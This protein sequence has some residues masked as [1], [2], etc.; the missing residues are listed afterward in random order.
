MSDTKKKIELILAK[1]NYDFYDLCQIVRILRSDKGC[2]WDREQTHKTIRNDFIEETYEVVE[3]ID[4]SDMILLREELGDVMLQVVFHSVIEEENGKFDINDVSNDIC[5]KLIH[6]H[7]HVFGDVTADTSA[8]VLDNW[9]KIKREEK[10]R[11]TVY[12]SM[13]SVPPMLPALMRARKLGARAAK[14]GFDFSSPDQAFEKIEEESIELKEA[15]R[16]DNALE[17]I[18][19]LLFSVVNVARILGI[20]P[21]EALNYSNNKFM[22]RFRLLEQEITMKGKSIQELSADELDYYYKIA[23]NKEKY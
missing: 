20:D 14:V 8:Q 16:T 15:M 5:K 13:K 21:E 2:P 12:D 23:K 4:N 3:A 19:D 9:D 6:R 17:E 18:G 7:P 11:N 22:E 10:S 1:D